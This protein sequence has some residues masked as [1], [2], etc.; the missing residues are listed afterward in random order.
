MKTINNLINKMLNYKDIK[1]QT[2]LGQINL[3]VNVYSSI[4]KKIE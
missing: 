4:I 3:I 2:Y 1:I